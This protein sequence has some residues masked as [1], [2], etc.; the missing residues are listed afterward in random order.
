MKEKDIVDKMTKT[1]RFDYRGILWPSSKEET[2]SEILK[3]KRVTIPNPIK[4][5]DTI[6]ENFKGKI[7]VI[8]SRDAYDFELDGNG[9]E[10]ENICLSNAIK[11]TNTENNT[12]VITLDNA[13]CFLCGRCEEVYPSLFRMGNNLNLAARNKGQL[14][15]SV[16][17][18]LEQPE[19]KSMNVTIAE[20]SSDDLSYEQIGS[21]LKEKINNLFGRSLAIRQVDGGSCN[22]CEIE[23]T[24]LNNPIYDIERFGIHFVSSPRHADVLLVTGPVSKNMVVA[25][26]KTFQATPD[27]KIVVAVGACACSGGIFGNT[28]ATT[29]G[30]DTIL[31]VD[32]YIPGCPPRPEALIYGLLT[33]MN[34]IET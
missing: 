1:N 19:K 8:H 16:E 29:G 6:S 20:K 21:E 14:I 15:D 30:V 25:L 28:Y 5:L 7:N 24:A 23:I 11:I 32:V 26:E 12:A 34:K 3:N 22:G 33:A 10:V 17:F 2:N 18:E 31:P 27:P 4:K 9:E 13:K